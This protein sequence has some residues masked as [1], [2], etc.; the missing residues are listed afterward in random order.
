MFGNEIDYLSNLGFKFT[1]VKGDGNCFFY[2]LAEQL[3]K[4]GKDNILKL[5]DE[6]VTESQEYQKDHE[7][8]R[9]VVQGKEYKDTQWADDKMIGEFVKNRLSNFSHILWASRIIF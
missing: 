3:N 9:S 1:N 4:V 6:F 2:A 5:R 7:F 8:L